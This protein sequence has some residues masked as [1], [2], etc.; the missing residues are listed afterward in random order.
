MKMTI[1][2]EDLI[3]IL[4][5]HFDTDFDIQ[6]IEMPAEFE[7]VVKGIPLPPSA[8]AQSRLGDAPSR[9]PP[10]TSTSSA[11]VYALPTAPNPQDQAYIA[12]RADADATVDPPPPGVDDSELLGNA[13]GS[14]ANLL[15]RSRELEAELTATLPASRRQGGSPTPPGSFTEEL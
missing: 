7:I 10:P 9:P 11:T 14:P 4:R 6:N 13:A 12:R 3:A 1:E 15:Q 2:R 8:R 5:E